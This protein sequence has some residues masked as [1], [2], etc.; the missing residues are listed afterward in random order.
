MSTE[1]NREIGDL[2]R[3]LR[4]NGG[5]LLTAIDIA[6]ND[7][8]G[9]HWTAN[10]AIEPRTLLAS[11]PHPLALSYLNAIVDDKYVVYKQ[12]HQQREL[13]IEAI[14]FFYLITQWLDPES[15][16]RPYLDTLPPVEE[17]F[18][19]PLWFDAIDD[20]D[21]LESTDVWHSAVARREIYERYYATGINLL[22]KSG[23][24]TQLYTW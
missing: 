18:T 15:F 11:T 14:G 23:V 1:R 2:H 7:R 19:S 9:Y 5:F 8:A 4:L 12:I 24:D 3:W 6:Y 17:G 10:K 22:K 21:F 20:M 16:W 13:A